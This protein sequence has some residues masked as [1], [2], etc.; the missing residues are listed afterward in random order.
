MAN[1]Q[2]QLC[3]SSERILK[4]FLDESVTNKAISLQ[5]W[6]NRSGKLQF[7]LSTAPSR[8]ENLR[9]TAN[10]QEEPVPVA[11]RLPQRAVTRP[12]PTITTRS[13]TTANKKRKKAP[14]T[15][16]VVDCVSSAQKD[17]PEI[18]RCASQQSQ[19]ALSFL[20]TDERDKQSSDKECSDEEIIP[21]MQESEIAYTSP[22]FNKNRFQA[23]SSSPISETEVSVG[24]HPVRSS[25]PEGH[26]YIPIMICDNCSKPHK[27]R[28]STT[29]LRD[30][31]KKVVEYWSEIDAF[32]SHDCLCGELNVCDCIYNERRNEYDDLPPKPDDA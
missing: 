18:P 28:K 9:T 22:F 2:Q 31:N 17:S 6:F 5:L 8:R 15:S 11:N 29:V 26:V 32:N 14:T 25:A 21:E 23:L 3:Q 27:T 4:L 10:L 13:T 30:G 1:Q 7:R 19:H 16:P 12:Q 24:H 20:D